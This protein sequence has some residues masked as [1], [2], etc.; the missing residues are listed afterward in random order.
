VAM[1]SSSTETT[2]SGQPKPNWDTSGDPHLLLS[3]LSGEKETP[4]PKKT[5]MLCTTSPAS[6]VTMA[7]FPQLDHNH[8]LDQISKK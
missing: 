6:T 5:L 7:T 2:P 8:A 4:P 3:L 1:R